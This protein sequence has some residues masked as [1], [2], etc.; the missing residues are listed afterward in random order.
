MSA[1]LDGREFAPGDVLFHEGDL[2]DVMYVIEEGSV[3]LTKDIDGE[4]TT[5]AELEAGD[6]LGE[7]AIVGGGTHTTTAVATSETRCLAVGGASLEAM[8]I[9]NEELAVRFIKSLGERL[10]ACHEMLALVGRR[11][12]RTRVVMAILRHAEIRGE[13]RDDGTW[14]GRRLGDIGDEVA[15]SKAE[16][17]EV[18][19]Q[20]LRLK[21]VRIKRDGILV[22]DVSRLYDFMKS[23]DA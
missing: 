18:S 7:L 14:I 6:F 9:S 19:T 1:E 13:Q 8:V 11:D 22:P 17:G 3:R 4:A 12:A 16:L 2:G 15:I 23:G 10:A 5:L 20:F 21:L